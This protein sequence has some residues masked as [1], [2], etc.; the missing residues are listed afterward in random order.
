M[1]ER[2]DYIPAEALVWA[3]GRRD[4]M[5]LIVRELLGSGE[6]PTTRDL[7]RELARQGRPVPLDDVFR[8]MPKLLG[9]VENNPRRVVLT[10]YGLRLTSQGYRLLEGFFALLHTA[11]ERFRGAGDTPIVTRAD[12]SGAYSDA[13]SEIVLREAPF[14]GS[15]SGG[16]AD[17]WSRE[18]TEVVVHYWNAESFEDYLRIRAG[19]LA[20]SPQFGFPPAQARETTQLTQ[21][22]DERRDVFVSHAS[23]DKA[24][25]ARPLADALRERGY[26]VW[27]DEY[28]LVLGDSLRERIEHGLAHSTIGIVILSHAFFAKRWPQEEL[29]GLYARLIRGEQNIIVPVW[30]GLTHEDVVGYAPT[31]ANR[32]AGDSADGVA[33]LADGI[34]RALT[35]RPPRG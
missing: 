1:A 10:L 6:W 9:W 17:D 33:N 31:L 15:G 8:S 18:V 22:P 16:R 4:L 20:A 28:E 25:I 2:P 34:E 19:E 7:T 35:R 29:N 3:D 26:T 23:E 27:Y 30:H 32:L 21:H 14:L 24:A 12:L 11:L 5:D 13:L